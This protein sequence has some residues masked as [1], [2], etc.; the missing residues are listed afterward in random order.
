MAFNLRIIKPE[1]HRLSKILC[2]GLHNEA[3]DLPKSLSLFNHSLR[4]KWWGKNK[5]HPKVLDLLE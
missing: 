3:V 5:K 4:G 2:I 1:Q